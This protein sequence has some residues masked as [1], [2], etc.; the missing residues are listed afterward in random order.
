MQSF[1]CDLNPALMRHATYCSVPFCL[2]FKDKG[3]G[4]EPTGAVKESL[5]FGSRKGAS[6][7]HEMP[8]DAPLLILIDGNVEG[9][10]RMLTRQSYANKVSRMIPG[11]F[12]ELNVRGAD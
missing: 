6:K 10:S 7:P 9:E 4:D 5:S 2:A 8:G 1:L 3:T 12:E 11:R